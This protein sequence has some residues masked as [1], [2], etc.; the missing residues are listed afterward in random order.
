MPK[1]L[2]GTAGHTNSPLVL[3]AKLVSSADQDPNVSL[4]RVVCALRP[5][6]F[7]PGPSETAVDE[8]LAHQAHVHR[9]AKIERRDMDKQ[10]R[11]RPI[12]LQKAAH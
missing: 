1:E 11:R 5:G 10:Y 9:Q 4:S 8:R 6:R 12:C 3:R 7:A 2:A